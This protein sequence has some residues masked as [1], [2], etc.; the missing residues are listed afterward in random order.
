MFVC[1]YHRKS[2]VSEKRKFKFLASFRLG[3]YHDW[4]SQVPLLQEIG[5]TGLSPYVKEIDL[6]AFQGAGWAGPLEICVI[7]CSGTGIGTG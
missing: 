1:I 6:A 2:I 5:R 3:S 7:I 4:A